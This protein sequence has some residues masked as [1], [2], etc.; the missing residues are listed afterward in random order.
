MRSTRT[1]CSWI[2]TCPRWVAS[3]RL[4]ESSLNVPTR[5]SSSV[6]LTTS[7]TCP[8][9]RRRVALGP[10]C[11]RNNSARRRFD[12]CGISET[13]SHS[14]RDLVQRQRTADRGAVSDL[15]L[16]AHG[17]ANGAEAVHHVDVTVAA[18]RTSYVEARTV[19]T[20]FE[21]KT[22]R[23][24]PHAHDHVRRGCVLAGVLQCL[25]TAEVDRCFDVAT[26]STDSFGDQFG[27]E[28]RSVGHRLQ[29]FAQAAVN[30]QW[31][32]D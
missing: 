13:K 16:P 2:S 1:S 26:I 27:V 14:R 31:R 19:I 29:G 18:L 23:L 4:V 5:S 9:T 8:R 12:V 25:E 3:R 32:I 10:T 15:G 7:V 24:F 28:W 30:Q 22:S 21:E 11:T 17:T 6:R 20:Y